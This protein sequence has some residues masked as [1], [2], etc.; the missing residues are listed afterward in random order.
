[1]KLLQRIASVLSGGRRAA[2]RSLIKSEIKAGIVNNSD[3]AK[4]ILA[5]LIKKIAKSTLEPITKFR[6]AIPG[7]RISSE[8]WNDTQKELYVDMFALYTELNQID[9]VASTSFASN[10]GDFTQSKAAIIKSLNEIEKYQFLKDNPEYQDLKYM[11]FSDA[12]NS[13]KRQ[14]KAIV[15]TNV[16]KLELGEELESKIKELAN[17]KL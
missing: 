17:L 4:N 7:E 8:D 12:R 10:L 11:D 5:S 14:P 1:M 9:K 15:D 6:E 13:T 3:E 16:R 2:L